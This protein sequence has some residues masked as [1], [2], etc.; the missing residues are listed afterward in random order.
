M[1]LSAVQTT[2]KRFHD[3]T[4]DQ[5]DEAAID[6]ALDSANNVRRLLT[7]WFGTEPDD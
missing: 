3:A 6:N 7:K 2:L 4:D 5:G 1:Q